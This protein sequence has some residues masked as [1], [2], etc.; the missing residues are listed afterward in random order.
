MH[1]RWFQ[2]FASELMWPEESCSCK[3]QKMNAICIYSNQLKH[4]EET[5]RVR[6]QLKRSPG[7][8]LIVKALDTFGGPPEA[9]A[10]VSTSTTLASY[11]SPIFKFKKTNWYILSQKT[12]FVV[13]SD[14]IIIYSGDCIRKASFIDVE[15]L[16][17]I[18]KKARENTSKRARTNLIN[19]RHAVPNII[20]TCL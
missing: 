19:K 4:K 3:F 5:L 2:L 15:D 13:I 6:E 1:E 17:Y 11:Q 14:F 20:G 16:L 9:S 12:N 10:W 18:W 8:P 7:K